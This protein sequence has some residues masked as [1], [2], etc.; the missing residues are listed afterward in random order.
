M[1]EGVSKNRAVIKCVCSY[2]DRLNSARMVIDLKESIMGKMISTVESVNGADK[3]IE[4]CKKR[5]AWWV[6]KG[7][8]IM[9]GIIL[10][11]V[12]I[13]GVINDWWVYS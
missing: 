11:T 1:M 7:Q 13:F 4:L 2:P 3:Y 6:F 9:V 8:M 5:E 12:Y 10:V